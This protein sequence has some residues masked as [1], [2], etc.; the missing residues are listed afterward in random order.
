M[1]DFNLT[2]PQIGDLGNKIGGDAGAKGI[3]SGE[4][5]VVK[6]SE[7]N[8]RW[9]KIDGN[10]IAVDLESSPGLPFKG[11]EVESHIGVGGAIYQKRAD[12]LCRNGRKVGL[13][14]SRRQVNGKS[15]KG[16]E[17]RD[18]L[19]GKPVL[20]ANE[21]DALYDNPHLIPE[22]WKRDENDN[23][24]FIYFWGT[25]YRSSDGS[26]Y[27]RCICFSDGAWDRRYYWL[28]GGWGGDYPATVAS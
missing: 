20:N 4:L 11:A 26:L 19:T 2:Y 25:I 6:R 16:Y 21:L 7:A 8:R 24:R 14:L 1:S 13:H 27:V 28:G 18:E 9:I 10:T 15:L 3:L 22:D 5:I 17:L 23:I 12:G